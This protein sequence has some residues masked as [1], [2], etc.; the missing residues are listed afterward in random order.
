MKYFTLDGK[1]IPSKNIIKTYKKGTCDYEHTEKCGRCFGRG[2]YGNYGVCYKCNGQCKVLAKSKGYN[3][4]QLIIALEQKA[5]KKAKDQKLADEYMVYQEK[6]D[7]LERRTNRIHDLIVTGGKGSDFA[8][9]I[10]RKLV[11]YIHKTH[12]PKPLSEKQLHWVFKFI[13]STDY[14]KKEKCINWI[15]EQL[16]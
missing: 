16:K 4:E 11:R 6:Q 12:K 7:K 13:E 3:K 1:E 14:P 15:K 8:R 2:I 9:D 5:E 10:A